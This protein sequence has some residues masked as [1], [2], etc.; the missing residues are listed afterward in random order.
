MRL[1]HLTT[2]FS[3]RP[4]CRADV[5]A[6]AALA[7]QFAQHM[8]ELG[9]NTPLGLD[10]VALERDGFGPDPAFRGLVAERDAE[11]VGY[12]LH[13]P[14]YDTDA[15]RRL[16]FI[17]DLFVSPSARGLGI[18]AALV[19]AARQIAADATAAQ[20]VWTVDRRNA[21]ALQFYQR[22]GAQSIEAL[23]LMCLDV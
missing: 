12:L 8:R 1:Q 2:T 20:L 17:V 15:A 3:L 5:P 7:E 16:V 6:I 13:H 4:A 21:G 9:D 11:V 19:G 22:L 10:A 23:D 14:G 18:G